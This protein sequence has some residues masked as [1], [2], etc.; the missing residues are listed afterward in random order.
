M[1]DKTIKFQAIDTYGPKTRTLFVNKIYNN[2][3]KF[4]MKS[5]IKSETNK[6]MKTTYGHLCRRDAKDNIINSSNEFIENRNIEESIEYLKEKINQKM[7]IIEKLKND[8]NLLRCKFNKSKTHSE[9]FEKSFIGKTKH[10][11]G[12]K[13]KPLNLSHN[14]IMLVTKHNKEDHFPF[15]IGRAHV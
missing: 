13:A 2:R 15:E 14:V 3:F 1:N 4:R 10:K 6:N 8:N 12:Y 11:I 9:V 7:N 5:I